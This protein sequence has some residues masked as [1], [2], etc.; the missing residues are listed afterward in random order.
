MI[1][2]FKNSGGLGRVFFFKYLR[3]VFIYSVIFIEY[4]LCTKYWVKCGVFPDIL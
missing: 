3:V 1:S 2:D 4:L